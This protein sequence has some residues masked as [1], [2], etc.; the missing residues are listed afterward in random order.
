M[1]DELSASDAVSVSALVTIGDENTT[2][3]IGP[4]WY[5]I[6]RGIIS[7]YRDH[8]TSDP[9]QPED[10]TNAIG[11]MAD[12]LN[13]AVRELALLSSATEIILA[14]PAVEA[15]AAVERG[16]TMTD[17]MFVLTRVAAEDVFRTL[18]T[19]TA[20]QR[21]QNPGLPN[22][23]VTTIAAGCCAVVAILR[24]LGLD[25]VTVRARQAMARDAGSGC[26]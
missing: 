24:G 7:L 17:R 12:H 14:G 8:F 21:K 15:I 1:S 10:L 13:D 25:E 22:H 11:D 5:E 3:A 20:S 23:L 2:I 18:A 19:E 16:E 9:P 4:Q 26:S 6:P